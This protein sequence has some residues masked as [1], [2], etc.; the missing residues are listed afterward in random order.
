MKASPNGDLI[1]IIDDGL[2]RS[3]VVGKYYLETNTLEMVD[4]YAA[5]L[6]RALDTVREYKR[7]LKLPA[8]PVTV[9]YW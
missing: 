7:T 6:P 5:H 9:V 2:F 8:A 4:G 3:N 1:L